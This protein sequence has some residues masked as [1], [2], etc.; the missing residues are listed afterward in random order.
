M[1]TVTI[2][3]RERSLLERILYGILLLAVLVLGFFFLAAALVAGAVLAG[4]LLLRFWWLKRKLRKAAEAEFIT[5]EYK[6][7]EREPPV[8]PNLPRDKDS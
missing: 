8:A 2:N 5:A 4:V 7:V 1:A 6:V 3:L